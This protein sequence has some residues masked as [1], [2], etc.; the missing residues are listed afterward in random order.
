MVRRRD[1]IHMAMR[2]IE[3]L[4]VEMNIDLKNTDSNL[5][6]KRLLAELTKLDRQY[7]ELFDRYFSDNSPKALFLLV[8]EYELYDYA[9]GYLCRRR[10]D[11]IK[12]SALEQELIDIREKIAEEEE[13]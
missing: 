3:D 8:S 13:E 11:P 12:P 9:I 7:E 5:E 10:S 4:T 6:T 1:L 2:G